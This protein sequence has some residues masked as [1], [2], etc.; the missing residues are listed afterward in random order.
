MLDKKKAGRN[1]WVRVRLHGQQ[2]RYIIQ[3]R[4]GRIM[5]R[6]LINLKLMYRCSRTKRFNLQINLYLLR[7]LLQIYG[8]R[9]KF[10]IKVART[11]CSNSCEKIIILL[12]AYIRTSTKLMFWIYIYRRT[13]KQLQYHTFVELSNF[14]RIS[15]S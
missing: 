12:N 8:I 4:N 15:F 5:L 14:V 10:L 11:L 7:W 3:L 2:V 6:R 13:T 9:T 1:S